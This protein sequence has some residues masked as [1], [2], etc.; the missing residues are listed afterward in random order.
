MSYKINF[1]NLTATEFENFCFDLLKELNFKDLNWRKGTGKSFSPADGGRDIECNYI[2]VDY[3][4]GETSVEKWFVECKHYI[5]GV[6]A[7][8][9]L[10]ILTSAIS[11]DINRCVIIVS[12][13]LS[14]SAKD[15]INNFI[16]KNKPRFKISVWERPKLEVLTKNMNSLL[17]KH[18]IIYRDD[19]LDDINP[20][21]IGYIKT[22]PYNK[23][24]EFF[25]YFNRLDKNTRDT[26]VDF[27]ALE[28]LKD[29][30][31]PEVTIYSNRDNIYNEL[32][33]T[34]NKISN[35][36]LENVVVNSITSTVLN[37]FLSSGNPSSIETEIINL[38]NDLK[39]ES[40]AI[41]FA[42]AQSC[43]YGYEYEDDEYIITQG[44]KVFEEHIR[45]KI[46][47]VE[48]CRR[49]Y[50]SIYNE[51]CDIVV[52]NLIY[53]DKSINKKYLSNL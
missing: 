44:R 28:Y 2:R 31:S 47:G 43:K 11:M 4:I 49:M 51:F 3:L 35:I 39:N 19:I 34:F 26:I 15:M 52:K 29:F 20:Y 53:N 25:K 42:Y 1:D 36:T 8:K 41:G 17:R 38:E 16:E 27:L 40:F 37:N 13:F 45:N 24:N 33:K 50:Y 30:F 10:G 9:L 18:N 14:N 6:P 21:H 22:N 12:N 46:S 23:L 5:K 48:P 32:L 7:D